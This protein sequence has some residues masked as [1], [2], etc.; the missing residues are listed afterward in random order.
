MGITRETFQASGTLPMMSERL[1]SLQRMRQIDVAV[2]YQHTTSDSVNP[3]SRIVGKLLELKQEKQEKVKWSC[4]IVG[5]SERASTNAII[6]DGVRN[7]C[8]TRAS[9]TITP[10]T[11]TWGFIFQKA[12]KKKDVFSILKVYLLTYFYLLCTLCN[13]YIFEICFFFYIRKKTVFFSTE[14]T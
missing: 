5:V 10:K 2:F 13:H 9:F 4:S 12:S 14:F 7:G 3:S 1:K 6:V 11:L 8:Q